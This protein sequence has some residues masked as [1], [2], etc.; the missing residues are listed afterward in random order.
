MESIKKIIADPVD[1]IT[2]STNETGANRRIKIETRNP[3]KGIHKGQPA[4]LGKRIFTTFHTP[5]GP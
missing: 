5:K 4:S 3:E 2:M 1:Q